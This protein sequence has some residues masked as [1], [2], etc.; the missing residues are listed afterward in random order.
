MARA[1]DFTIDLHVHSV[2]SGESLAEPKDII[3]AALQKGLDAI[4][5]T[6]H[7]S[8]SVSLPF[9]EISKRYPLKVFR[10]VEISTDAGHMLVYGVTD[11]DWNDWGKS[12]SVHAQELI[13]KVRSLGGVVVPAHPYVMESCGL[14]DANPRVHVDE[15]I[16]GLSGLKALEI[17]NGKTAKY[18]LVCGVLSQYARS[19]GLAGT[20]GSDA[21][22]PENVGSSYTVFKTPIHTVQAL[23][24]AI[25][26]GH[27]YPRVS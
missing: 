24:A 7:D 2:F 21:H 17:C 5:I 20:G 23:A 6:E 13:S 27:F 4:C 14:C 15:R 16:R 25:Q 12:G 1:R 3:E 18:P 22:I 8:L 10:G 19:L 11:A 9:D 26:S